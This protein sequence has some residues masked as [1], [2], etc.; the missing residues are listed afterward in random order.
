MKRLFVLALIGLAA[1]AFLWHRNRAAESSEP[2]LP[3]DPAAA[4]DIFMGNMAKLG[5]LMWDEEQRERLA[6]EAADLE[7]R[8]EAEARTRAKDIWER[9]GL[10]SP[11]YLFAEPAYGKAVQAALLLVR[12][13]SWDVAT[14]ETTETT[15][16]VDASF[17]PADVLGIG[18]AIEKLGA[19]S[20]VRRR[21]PIILT[22]HLG[23]HGDGWRITSTSGSLQSTIDAFA[24]V[25]ARR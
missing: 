2:P 3:A 19:P 21:E 5:A 16:R 15:A 11:L 4:V 20:P 6:T 17:V 13:E 10:T 7:G 1:A 25:A 24:K 23:R 12:F 8:P 14:A 22:F 9:Y 18:Q